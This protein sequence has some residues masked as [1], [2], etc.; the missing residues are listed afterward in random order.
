VNPFP[1]NSRSSFLGVIVKTASDSQAFPYDG[2][3][4]RYLANKE[5]TG[6]QF[7]LVE[8]TEPAGYKTPLH[9]HTDVDEAFF[10]IEGD[11]T[12]KIG[13][14]EPQVFGPGSFV[15]IPRGTVHAQGNLGKTPVKILVL[16]LPGGLERFFADR[17]ELFRK[18]K[19]GDPAFEE[20]IKEVITIN[21]IEVLGPWNP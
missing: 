8:I 1:D 17:V 7:S 3:S 13:D 19:P 21:H 15:L 11:L 6:L 10:V 12:A 5:E 4:V 2:G 14:R 18:G 20:R 16:T 9:R